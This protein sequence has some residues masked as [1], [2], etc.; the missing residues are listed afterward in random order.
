[1]T[2][3]VIKDR[4]DDRDK[5]GDRQIGTREDDCNETENNGTALKHA[6]HQTRRE[7][8]Q[9]KKAAIF[10]FFPWCWYARNKSSFGLTI[11][12]A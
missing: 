6:T 9:E 3:G 2:K 5:E 11:L 12:C 8:S 4:W 10:F 7:K 1:M